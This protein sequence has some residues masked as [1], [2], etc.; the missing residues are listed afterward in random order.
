[1]NDN[2]LPV[3]IAVIISAAI[4][5]VFIF[6]AIIVGVLLLGGLSV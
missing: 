2:G 5:G 3:F 6:A 4:I 1:M